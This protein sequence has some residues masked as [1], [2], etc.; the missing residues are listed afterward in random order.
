MDH[1]HLFLLTIYNKTIVI[2]TKKAA[3]NTNLR[4]TKIRKIFE[5]ST[6]DIIWTQDQ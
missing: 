6:N 5:L 4:K 2:A 1:K 3:T